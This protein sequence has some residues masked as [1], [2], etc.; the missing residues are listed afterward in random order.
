MGIIIKDLIEDRIIKAVREAQS[1]GQIPIAPIPSEIVERPQ[2]SSHGDFATAIGLKLARSVQM[3]PM[4]I[5]QRISQLIHTGDELSRVTVASP[6]FINFSLSEDWLRNQVNLILEEGDNF[7]T[8]SIGTGQ[9]VQLEFVSVNPTGP[10]HVGH[11]RGA[12]L[13]SALSAILEAAG[14]QVTNEYY[15]NDAGSQMDNFYHSLHSRYLQANGLS[16]EIPTDGYPGSYLIDLANSIIASEGSKFTNMA[17]QQ[18]IQELGALGLQQMIIEIK[19]DLEALGVEFDIWFSEKTLFANSYYSDVMKLLK[20]G[21]YV[22]ERDGAVWFNSSSL[23]ED[24]DNVL[25]RSNGVPTY[26]ASDAAYH[27]EKFIVR[28]FDWVTNIWG[29]DHQGHVSR[30]KAVLS[31]LGVDPDRLTIILAQMMTLRRGS[32]IVRVSKR[33]GELVTLRELLE[34]VGKDACRFFYLSRSPQTQMEFDLE[35]ATRQSQENPVFYIQYAHARAASIL[36]NANERDLDY[37]N[38]DGGLLQA[39]PELDLIRHL[40]LLPELIASMSK[41]LEPHHLPHYTVELATA[42]HWFYD[43]C[44][45]ISE[46][47]PLSNARL[48]LVAA[49]RLVLS[50][51]LSLMGMTAPDKM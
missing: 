23:G 32:E 4:E 44:R 22:S 47:L 18:A 6:G 30:L 48:K 36:R 15:V 11:A 28:K 5:A 17:E 39:S 24:R 10:L 7:G 41:S 35:L 3:N 20:E 33:T 12:V 43:Q 46:D 19:S 16:A 14:Y 1:L 31:A 45:V 29:A 42:F 34:E 25:V 26:F 50:L 38:S 27:Y 13:G 49:S 40:V 37:L 9:K 21:G 8:L 2:H 51:C